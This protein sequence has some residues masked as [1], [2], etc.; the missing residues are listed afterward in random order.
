MSRKT[1]W[2]EM[3]NRWNL[4]VVMLERFGSNRL[5]GRDVGGRLRGGD[6]G[7][8]WG[9]GWHTTVLYFLQPGLQQTVLETTIN[10][11][12]YTYSPVKREGFMR[13][14]I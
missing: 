9:E 11:T 1:F 4:V 6:V 12:T 14:T 7:Q 8:G 3:D 10:L 5:G 13:A 2:I